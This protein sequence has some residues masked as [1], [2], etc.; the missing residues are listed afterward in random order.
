VI[1]PGD[2]RSLFISAA[3]LPGYLDR[4]ALVD[5]V[6]TVADVVLFLVPI[7][8]WIFR[9]LGA[10]VRAVGEARLTAAVIRFAAR[11]GIPAARAAVEAAAG[12]AAVT[13]DRAGLGT[14]AR[15]IDESMRG[16]AAD[17]RAAGT[18]ARST[19]EV[20]AELGA[21]L[22]TERPLQGRRPSA[23]TNALRAAAEGLIDPARG[24]LGGSSYNTVG[25]RE[26]IR[27][28]LG[29]SATTEGAHVLPQAIGAHIPGYSSGRAIAIPLETRT[30]RMF[31]FGIDILGAERPPTG[32]WYEPWTE[33][34]REGRE[35]TAAD[36]YQ[37]V[38]QAIRDIPDDMMSPAA[39]GTLESRLYQEMFRD[40][41]LELHTVIVP[42]R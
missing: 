14:A 31:D 2:T 5:L 1:P 39:R 30:H 36:V 16:T 18:D 28:A 19:D 6:S 22:R 32:G 35:I 25:G 37:W 11:L 3:L 40:L 42:A 38:S 41:G 4:Q 13:V 24:R 8:G 20:F 23:R 33:A 9:A 15:A 29:I 34:L 10:I 12:R 7:E 17:L 27:A 21:E 26:G